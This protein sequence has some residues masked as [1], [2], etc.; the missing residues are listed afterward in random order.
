ML[1]V[2]ATRSPRPSWPRP[3]GGLLGRAAAMARRETCTLAWNSLVTVPRATVM[4]FCGTRHMQQRQQCWCRPTWSGPAWPDLARSDAAWEAAAPRELLR[5]ALATIA[6]AAKVHWLV[7]GC[8]RAAAVRA[9]GGVADGTMQDERDGDE[10]FRSRRCASRGSP[11]SWRTC[12]RS[13]AA[14]AAAA[15]NGRARRPRTRLPSNRGQGAWAKPTPQR[16]RGP[17]Q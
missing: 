7:M 6:A 12:R 8:K 3:S 17:F 11:R 1:R 14:A 4:E 10:T 15:P 13:T 9:A 5:S 2:G 16:P